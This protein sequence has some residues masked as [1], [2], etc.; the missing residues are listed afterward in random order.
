MAGVGQQRDRIAEHA[1]DRLQNDEAGVEGDPDGERLAEV[2]GRI[3]VAVAGVRV[4][5]MPVMIVI[6]PRGIVIMAAVAVVRMRHQTD[7]AASGCGG[8]T[9]LQQ[10]S[11]MAAPF[12]SSVRGA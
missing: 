8:R 5:V 6:V 1:V 7:S 9:E 4:K 3:D 12:Q 10:S 11:A 2:F